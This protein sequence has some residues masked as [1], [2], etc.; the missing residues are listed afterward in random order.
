MRFCVMGLSLVMFLVMPAGSDR[1]VQRSAHKHQCDV[2]RTNVGFLMRTI[3]IGA[4][5]LV[6]QALY[7][8]TQ[9]K[10][11]TAQA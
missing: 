6:R 3:S 5:R 11:L 8:L 7:V 1:Q 9:P 2:A 10:S 4:N